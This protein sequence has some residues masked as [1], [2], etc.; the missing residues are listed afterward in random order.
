MT[1]NDVPTLLYFE[2]INV[3][4]IYPLSHVILQ[5]ERKLPY[6]LLVAVPRLSRAGV[7]SLMWVIVIS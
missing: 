3:C 6:Q 5:H 2:I 7:E 1:L 4:G